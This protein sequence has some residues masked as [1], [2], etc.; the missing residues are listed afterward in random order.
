MENRK[1]LR[2]LKIFVHIFVFLVVGII[3][4][5]SAVASPSNSLFSFSMYGLSAVIFYYLLVNKGLKEFI[6]GGAFA[7][8]I[9]NVLLKPNLELLV[10][11]RNILWYILIG[12]LTFIIYKK[13]KDKPALYTAA[14]WFGGFILVY[15]IMAFMNMYVFSF[16][17]LNGNSTVLF[18]IMQSVKIGGV[19]GLGIGFGKILADF[20]MRND[21]SSAKSK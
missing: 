17:R 19:L 6:L 5:G 10:Y 14:S 9:I 2:E 3:L 18:Y 11:T 21:L 7:V 16:Y 1:G 20:L 4:L 13:E 8:F 12:I 15:L